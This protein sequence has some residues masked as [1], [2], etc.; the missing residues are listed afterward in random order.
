MAFKTNKTKTS[1]QTDQTDHTTPNAVAITTI[2]GLL[3]EIATRSYEGGFFVGQE[4]V[5]VDSPLS[6]DIFPRKI[7]RQELMDAIAA[8]FRKYELG[9]E[10]VSMDDF[11]GF[12]IW[13]K[14]DP[15]MGISLRGVALHCPSTGLK[16][17]DGER[18]F[19]ALDA[20]MT[21]KDV[22]IKLI[23]DYNSDINDLQNV[24]D[25]AEW[26]NKIDIDD[27]EWFR[28]HTGRTTVAQASSEDVERA[29]GR[30]QTA[31]RREGTD[32]RGFRAG[33][34]EDRRKSRSEYGRTR[35]RFGRT[36][37]PGFQQSG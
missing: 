19:A 37:D 5:V 8:V 3:T 15:E 7:E 6:L 9:E 36:H 14:T 11:P 31:H 32:H 25:D 4:I 23:C 34:H 29:G 2:V 12:T 16:N 26:E 13:R 28:L 24:V 30:L 22:T 21:A 1:D 10:Q 33:H 20:V 17:V 35:K 27:V 18:G